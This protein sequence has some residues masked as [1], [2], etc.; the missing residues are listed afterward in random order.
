MSDA[1]YMVAHARLLSRLGVVRMDE[2]PA[3]R[4]AL[5]RRAAS[6]DA[7]LDAFEAEH[8]VPR[9]DDPKAK[10]YDPKAKAR[11]RLYRELGLEP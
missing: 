6:L 8:G 9:R 10:Q 1:R 7:W 4:Q 5:L 11:A 3:E 2:L